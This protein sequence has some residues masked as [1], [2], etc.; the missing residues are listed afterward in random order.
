MLCQYFYASRISTVKPGFTFHQ[1]A[2]G[3]S[4]KNISAN[5]KSVCIISP[6][7]EKTLD[8]QTFEK[9][10]LTIDNTTLLTE[11]KTHSA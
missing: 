11:K 9:Q 1:D 5:V 10:I 3:F 8:Y 7:S 2:Q 6:K 4:K